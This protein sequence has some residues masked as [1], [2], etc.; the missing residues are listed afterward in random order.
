MAK[1]S[2]IPLSNTLSKYVLVQD[3]AADPDVFGIEIELEGKYITD[4]PNNVHRYWAQH[5]DGSLRKLAPGDEA[6]EYVS[7][8]PFNM[9]VTE[10]ILQDLLTFLNTPPA[11]VYDSYRTSVHV[12]VNCSQETLL[13]IYNFMTLS[14]LLDELL[15]SQNGEHR[16]G[17]NFCLRA[18]D[19]MGQLVALTNSMENGKEFFNFGVNERYSSINFA[20]L[21]KFGTIEFRSLECTLHHGRIMHW[22]RTLQRMKERSRGFKNPTEIIQL[23]SRLGPQ[24]FLQ[25]VLGPY[26]LKYIQ[27][28]DMDNMLHNGMRLA[29]DLAYS[30]NWAE[31]PK[32]RSQAVRAYE[33]LKYEGDFN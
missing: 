21:M 11:V 15:V 19:A 22:V 10:K 24:E 2:N 30:N 12:H 9:E 6:T 26:A 28:P 7:R 27:V 33:K 20:S 23:Y 32:P 4:V 16:I 25:D 31:E 5:N 17:N 14:L 13:T 3:A 1:L 8:Y 29:Q 18:K